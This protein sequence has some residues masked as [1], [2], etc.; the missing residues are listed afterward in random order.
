[1]SAFTVVV[2]ARGYLEADRDGEVQNYLLSVQRFDFIVTLVTTEHGLESLLP[3]TTFLQA[4]LFRGYSK[5]SSH[6]HLPAAAREGRSRDM[7]YIV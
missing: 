4:K 5:G 7:E 3:L 2:S 6:C 1:M